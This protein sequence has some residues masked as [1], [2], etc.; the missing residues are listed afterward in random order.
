[1]IDTL[2][3][4]FILDIR[5]HDV[6]DIFDRFINNKTF[7]MYGL[8]NTLFFLVLNCEVLVDVTFHETIVFEPMLEILEE[9]LVLIIEI[10]D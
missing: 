9:L 10:D 7:V 3:L 5:L 2:S 1:M 4:D 8:L 6:N